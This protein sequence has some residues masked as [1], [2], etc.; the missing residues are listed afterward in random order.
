MG[1][2]PYSTKLYQQA[3]AATADKN[4]QVVLL[5][6]SAVRFLN[7]AR[8]AMGQGHNEE[9]CTCIVRTQRIF[10][11]LM[12]SLDMELAPE[13]AHALWGTYNWIHAN[14]TEASMKDDLERLDSVI[15]VTADLRNA[16]RQA[17][18]Q[19]RLEAENLEAP[20]TGANQAA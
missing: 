4:Q 17:A 20:A 3:E 7:R 10:S 15:T 18:A 8:M 12:A 2:V 16:W 6:D 14:L 19:C 13:L 5:F 1:D 9:Q 11:T